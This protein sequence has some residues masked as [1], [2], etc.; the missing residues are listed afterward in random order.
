[1]LLPG[2]VVALA[3]ERDEVDLATENALLAA[4]AS[5]I[6][7]VPLPNCSNSNTPTGPFQMI[8]P[9]LRSTS[10]KRAAVSAPMSRIISSAATASTAFSVAAASAANASA[11]T[12]SVGTGTSARPSP[13]A[14]SWRAVSSMSAS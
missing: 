12:T 13:P 11:T 6:A 7:C 10:L 3:I 14:A 4:I 8:V 9:A 2:G 5:A 1:M